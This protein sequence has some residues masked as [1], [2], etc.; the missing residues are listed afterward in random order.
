M[1]IFRRIVEH[2]GQ[3]NRFAMYCKPDSDLPDPIDLDKLRNAY[4]T[5][6]VSAA[7]AVSVPTI[8]LMVIC[9]LIEQHHAKALRGPLS[10]QQGYAVKTEYARDEVARY[11][12]QLR[13]HIEQSAED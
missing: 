2:W 3:N 7:D 10:G 11:L 5:V 8:D 13:P 6:G 9:S 12:D 4:F 1:G